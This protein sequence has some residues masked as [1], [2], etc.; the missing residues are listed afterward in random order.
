MTLQWIS[1]SLRIPPSLCEAD[2]ARKD[3]NGSDVRWAR[4]ADESEEK[5]EKWKSFK[6]LDLSSVYI[7]GEI[8]IFEANVVFVYYTRK[9]TQNYYYL[10]YISEVSGLKMC[11]TI[12]PDLFENVPWR[13]RNSSKITWEISSK[14]HEKKTSR[15]FIKNSLLNIK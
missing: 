12:W 2:A 4:W 15:P 9:N 10:L 8:M 14:N 3:V 6:K 11:L 1:V 7:H 5:G 13:Y